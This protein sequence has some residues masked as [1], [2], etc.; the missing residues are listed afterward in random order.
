M[1]QN[2]LLFL[3]LISGGIQAQT[4]LQQ[5][6]FEG[7]GTDI[8]AANGYTATTIDPATVGPNP[9]IEYFERRM[10]TAVTGGIGYVGTTQGLNNRQGDY[11]WTGEGVRGTGQTNVRPAG[12]VTLNTIVNSQN[13][14]SFVITAAFAAPRGGTFS[15]FGNNQVRVTDRIR[16]QYSFGGGV[17]TTVAML[18]GNNA[19]GANQG[20]D[21]QQLTTLSDSTNVANGSTPTGNGVVL[22]Q[23]YRDITATLPSTALGANLQVRVVLDI[24]LVEIAFDNIRVTGV[25]DITAKPTLTNVESTAVSYT[26]GSNPVPLTS[27]LVVGYSDNSGTTL[28]GGA[29]AIGSFVTGQDV[30]NFTNQNGITGSYNTS[31]GVLTL[32]GTATQAAYQA[33]LRT[34]TYS[35]SNTATATGGAR[36]VTFQVYNGATL[37]TTAARTITVTSVLNPPVSLNYT[38]SFDTDGEGTR[39]FGNQ[40]ANTAG[41]VGFFRATT[42]PATFN[43]SRIGEGVFTGW[44]GSYWFGEGNDNRNNLIAPISTLQLAPVNAGSRSTIKFTIALGA[45]GN[46][47]GYFN[48]DNPG[49]RFELYYSINGANP[50]KFGAFYGVDGTAPARQD[51]DLDPLTPA[52]GTQLTPALQDFTFDLPAST[53]V[54]NLTFLLRQQARGQSEIA[55]DNI[56]ITAAALVSPTVTTNSPATN[57]STSSAGVGGTLL[58][59]GGTSLTHY[60][61]VYVAGT[62]TPTTANSV[63]QVGTSSP[64]TFPATFPASLTGLTAGTRYTARAYATNSVGTSYGSALSFTTLTPTIVVAP[65][66]LPDGLVGAAYTQTLTA[67]GGSAPYS[68]TITA[69]ALP[70][71]LTLSPAGTLSGTPTVVGTFTFTIRAVDASTGTGPFSGSRSYSVTIQGLNITGLSSSPA[72]V[73]TGSPVTVTATIGNVT[74][75][76]TYTLT[77]GA[78]T[79]IA[80]SSSNT[81][82]SQSLTAS[83]SGP[84]PFT[85]TVRNGTQ[86]ALATTSLTVNALPVASLIASGGLSCTAT[87]VTL[88]AAPGGT[89]YAFSTGATQ[90]GTGNRATVL[91]AGTYSVTVTNA[92][93]CRSTT[94][95]TITGNNT[96]DFSSVKNGQWNDPTVWSCG[97]IPTAGSV[98]TVSHA[99]SLPAGYSA[100]FRQLRYGSGGKVVL[101]TGGRLQMAP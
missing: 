7:T 48:A 5:Q 88:T 40:F 51:S 2:L 6:S 67:S 77:N 101:S 1:R 4:L 9:A 79:S 58:A 25:P 74:G 19:L 70:G 96:V 87:S 61:V 45:S 44:S 24:K 11:T 56:R 3:V 95:I 54:G 59:D 83:G 23:T 29:V 36:S 37:S 32:S 57:V 97:T 55:F 15:G 27:S 98:V 14:K 17:W 92:N 30:L 31:T 76:Y 33:A 64:A 46:W 21:F 13:Y 69:G 82:F 42:A 34:I 28:T 78:G 20:A 68:Y 38:E 71:G 8:F 66:T 80:A 43:G 39:Y 47:L 49:D 94:S 86:T 35:N 10:F 99:V 22:D 52:T 12:T 100:Q 73:C 53:A 93:G 60:G 41:E 72:A 91:T 50:V 26:E 75:S 63:V 16:I 84:Q 18:M 85:L 89:T 90:I 62:A 65:A 81:A